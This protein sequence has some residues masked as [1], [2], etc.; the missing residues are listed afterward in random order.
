MRRWTFYTGNICHMNMPKLVD[1][2]LDGYDIFK[3]QQIARRPQYW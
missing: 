2:V 1:Q 3:E